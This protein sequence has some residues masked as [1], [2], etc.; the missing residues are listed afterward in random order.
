MTSTSAKPERT[1]IACRKR[2]GR[3]EMM[4]LALISNGPELSVCHDEK[5]IMAGRGAWVCNQECLLLAVK[6]KALGRA[7]KIADRK[8]EL[9]LA[10]F[11]DN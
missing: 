3:T 10:A 6:R 2:K 7:F 11:S 5:K 9:D 8:A 1:C 4:R